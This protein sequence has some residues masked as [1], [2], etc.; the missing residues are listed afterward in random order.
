MDTTTI[1]TWSQYM[2]PSSSREWS[3]YNSAQ[4][5]C[6]EQR[7]GITFGPK[8]A[9]GP[10]ETSHFFDLEHIFVRAHEHQPETAAPRF[11]SLPLGACRLQQASFAVQQRHWPHLCE[12]ASIPDIF[13]SSCSCRTRPGLELIP[14]QGLPSLQAHLCQQLRQTWSAM[15]P[16]HQP[17]SSRQFRRVRQIIYECAWTGH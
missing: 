14:K 17:D 4:A 9:K 13:S 6:G 1:H 11:I 2:E 10:R 7:T 16:L 12:E 8:P 3:P 15:A 5:A